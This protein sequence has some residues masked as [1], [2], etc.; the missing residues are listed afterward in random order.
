M[1]ENIVVYIMENEKKNAGK[2]QI[3]HFF[4]NLQLKLFNVNK[5]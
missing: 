3:A 4:H 1:L 2:M 5:D